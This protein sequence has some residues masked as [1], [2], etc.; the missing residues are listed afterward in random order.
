MPVPWRLLDIKEKSDTPVVWGGNHPTLSPTRTLSDPAVDVIVIGD[1]EE[2]LLALADRISAKKTLKGIAGLWFKEGEEIVKNDFRDPV[3][4]NT[5]PPPPYNLVKVE[6][7]VQEYRGK[8][9]LNI[10]TSRGCNFRCRYCYHTGATGH[11][12]FRYLNAE[13]SLERMLWVRDEFGVDGVY[14]IDDNFFLDMNRGM[15]VVRGLVSESKDLFWQ[16]Q[17]VDVPSMLRF[18]HS[19]LDELEKSGLMRISV[20]AESGSPKILKYIRKPHTVEMINEANRLWSSHGIF[21]F[22]SWIAGFPEETEDDVK[23]TIAMM[24]RVIRDNPHARVSPLYNFLPFP[25]TN[26]W[27]EVIK[28]YNFKPPENLIDWGEYDFKHVNASYLTP[29]MKRLLENLYIP[30]LC[31]DHKFDDYSM[32][33]WFN[34][35]LMMYRPLAFLR[36]KTV[37]PYFPVETIPATIVEKIFAKKKVLQKPWTL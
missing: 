26:L 12:N 3:D 17:G 32:P 9:V 10:E 33:W 19:D 15:E 11:H 30:S 20:G 29:R 37:F 16:I 1:G 28:N 24:F 5:L 35:G 31:I 23:K 14:L 36:M 34:L 4:M 22:Y 2:T 7:Y 6:D 8:K 18:G 25:G 27:E 21:V 13:K